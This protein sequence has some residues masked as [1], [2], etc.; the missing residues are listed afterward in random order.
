MIFNPSYSTSPGAAGQPVGITD[1]LNVRGSASHL[2]HRSTDRTLPHQPSPSYSYHPYRHTRQTNEALPLTVP[3]SSPNIQPRQGQCA[4]QGDSQNIDDGN[5]RN[6]GSWDPDRA[7][8]VPSATNF[9]F[10]AG[11]F[12]AITDQNSPSI[13][14]SDS[15]STI[16]SAHTSSIRSGHVSL[17]EGSFWAREP[18]VDYNLNISMPID[19]PSSTN[20][21]QSEAF[22]NTT[23]QSFSTL[24][25][26][27]PDTAASLFTR[28]HP[29]Q[30]EVYHAIGS[31]GNR[32]EYLNDLVMTGMWIS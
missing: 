17:P 22:S 19:I 24:S 28:E 18:T 30:P 14:S 3:H 26:D 9:D 7:V 20:N 12:N 13:V 2:F 16:P 15:I 10:L 23:Y 29:L 25:V 1:A 31:P 8:A 4:A 27:T 5:S 32:S 21:F 6:L 11:P